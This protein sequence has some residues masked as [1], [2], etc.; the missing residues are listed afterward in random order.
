[1]RKKAIFVLGYRMYPDVTG[2]MEIFNYQLI[3]SLQEEMDISYIC[4][5]DLGFGKARCLLLRPWRPQKF[6]LPLQVFR[7]LLRHR[8][9]RSVVFS[10]SE[11]SS[12]IWLQYAWITRLLHLRSTVVIHFGNPSAG[13]RNGALKAFFRSAAQ[14]I[15]VSEDIKR[16][17]DAA[18]GVDCRVVPPTIPFLPS[19]EDRAA[20]RD[21]W[22]IAPDRFVI[23]MAGSLKGMKNPDTVLECL[24]RMT[25]EENATLRPFLLL[26]GDGPM[27][28]A[29]E[30]SVEEAGLQDRVRFL[31]QLPQDR[32]RDVLEASDCYVS[33]SDFEG[34][35]LSLMEAMSHR[36]PIVASDVPGL[37]DMIRDGRNGLLFVRRDPE[38]LRDCLLRIHADPAL[39]RLLGENAARDFEQDYGFDR[40]RRTYL[41]LL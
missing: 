23:C 28:S 20:L 15:A 31:G 40:V 38:S 36:L 41:D 7:H 29:L 32:I 14:V 16:N 4:G 22:G 9:I 33:A 26:A 19:Q 13:A 8:E 3:R 1:M 6:L 12:L 27:R 21:A 25:P 17:Y 35:S 11:A 37:R 39:A 24:A 5:R 18:F 2:G 10:Y 30:R 34:T